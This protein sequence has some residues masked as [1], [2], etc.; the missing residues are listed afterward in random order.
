MIATESGS[1]SSA[2]PRFL[3]RCCPFFASNRPGQR[4]LDP[5]RA[6]EGLD[7]G[8]LE[9]NQPLQVVA[10]CHHR[11]RKV[12]ARPADGAQQL[13]AH[14][15]DGPEHMLDPRPRPGDALVASLLAVGQ[16]LVAMALAL[17]L[18]AE[19]VFLQPG[20]P[21][22]RRIAPVGIDVPARV[23][24]IEDVVEVLA[25]VRARRV[26][27]DLADDLVLRV[28]VDGELVAEVALA[29]FLG[30][31]GVEVLLAP[32]GG[33]PAGRHRAL[34]NQRF[35]APAV[36][37]LGRRHQGRV[38]D[39]TTAGDEALFEQLR[40]DTVEQRLCAGFADA[41]LEGPHRGAVGNVRCVRQPAEALVAHAIE[42]LVLHLLVR[43]V[44]QP[45]QDQDAH[46]RLGRVRRAAT[47]GA[48]RPGRDAIDL[49]RQRH[50]VDVGLD[51]D[52]RIAQGIDLLAVMFV[53]E[54]VGLDGAARFHRSRLGADSERCN[55]IKSGRVEVF[56]GALL[57]L[58]KV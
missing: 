20:F 15:V 27:L 32:L 1:I 49:G 54:Q 51:L 55:F 23:G 11:H 13:A 25:V 31:G 7:S 47:L 24:R 22:R 9:I 36:V 45:L 41:V 12:R 53:C 35:L 30:P 8:L 38:N 42:Q 50:E 5:F 17:D 58:A 56:R 57:V 52:Q 4:R 33:L 37:L 2:N 39:L 14:L 28:D 10:G 26:G 46:H 18:V 43:Q 34:L 3:R 6:S 16:R 48:D 44:V 21:L 40:R 19:A 29:V